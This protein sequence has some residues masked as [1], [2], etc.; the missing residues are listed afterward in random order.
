MKQDINSRIE[1]LVREGWDIDIIT[2]IVVKE[3]HMPEVPARN[4]ILWVSGCEF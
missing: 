1:T 4:Y 3:Y 2:D